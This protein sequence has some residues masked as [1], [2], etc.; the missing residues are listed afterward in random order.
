MFADI[1]NSTS[2]DLSDLMAMAPA[3]L[4][5]LLIF[6]FLYSSPMAK[7]SDSRSRKESVGFFAGREEPRAESVKA[8][9]TWMEI[10]SEVVSFVL[11][12]VVG[13]IFEAVSEDAENIARDLNAIK[14]GK[15]RPAHRIEKWVC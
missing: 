13:I 6:A 10:L 2:L 7:F 1:T 3:I 8:K 12:A 14:M 9:V 15:R 11:E 5:A 4:L